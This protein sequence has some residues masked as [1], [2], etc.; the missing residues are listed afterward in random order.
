MSLGEVVLKGP[1]DKRGGKELGEEEER[2]HGE[3]DDAGLFLGFDL[4]PDQT[5]GVRGA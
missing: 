2:S 1:L 4:P 5:G 3:T